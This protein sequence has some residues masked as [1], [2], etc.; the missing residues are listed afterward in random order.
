MLVEMLEVLQKYYG[1]TAFR[2]GQEEVIRHLLAKRDALAVMPTGAGKSICYQ[3]PAL[4]MPGITLVIS[5]LISLMQDQVRSLLS[6][7]VRGAYLNS[8]LTPRQLQLATANARRGVYKIIYAAPERLMTED[9]LD[10]ACH[11][12]IALVAVDEAHC[13]SQWGHDFRPS[14]LS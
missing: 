13:I 2:P 8:T 7:G 10:F 9:F 3:V 1:Y 12:P 11:S 14:V 5:P 6:I 4:M